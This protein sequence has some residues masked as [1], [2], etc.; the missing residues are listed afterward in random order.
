MGWPVGAAPLLQRTL[1]PRCCSRS[2]QL[3]AHSVPSSAVCAL[4]G[5]GSPEYTVKLCCSKPAALK[6][7]VPSYQA[8]YYFFAVYFLFC[9]FRFMFVSLMIATFP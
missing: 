4:P 3:S 2:L 9:E 1:S 8:C 6:L 7:L 5:A